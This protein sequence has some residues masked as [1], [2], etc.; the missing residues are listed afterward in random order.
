[1]LERDIERPSV[2]DARK[3]GF[4]VRKYK[5][6]GRRSAPDDIFARN[7]RVFFIEYKATGCEP[8]ELQYEEHKTM[9]EHG[10]T[11]YWTDSREGH[12]R[13]M[14]RER[15]YVMGMSLPVGWDYGK[16]FSENNCWNPI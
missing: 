2:K 9:R 16:A 4:Y 12:K 15:P 8:T 13:I 1:M 3:D 11:V 5:A 6:P 10:L 14:E 7:G